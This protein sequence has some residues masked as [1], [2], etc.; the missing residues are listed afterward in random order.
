MPQSGLAWQ[1]KP[2]H[3]VLVLLVL[4]SACES[5]EPP[6]PPRVAAAKPA[7]RMAESTNART[8]AAP[9]LPE[10]A[11]RA[12]SPDP[13]EGMLLVPG[14]TFIMGADEGGEPDEQPA[15]EVTVGGFFLDRTEVTNQAY[16]VCVEAQKCGAHFAKSAELNGFGSDRA[17]RGP[18]QPVSAVGWHDAGAYCAFVNRR[19][20]TEAEWERAARGADGRRYP[21]GDDEPTVAH[22]RYRSGQT[23]DV[24]SLPAGAGPYGHLDLAGNVWEWVADPYDPLAYRRPS[25]AAGRVPTCSEAV[26]AY[27]E[28]RAEGKRGFTGSNPIPTECE[29]VLRG[30]AFNYFPGG[31]RTTNRVHHEPTARLVMSGFRCAADIPQ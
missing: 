15:H 26:A 12:S 8:S 2:V 27:V 9:A 19:L 30:G 23:A 18:E 14:G 22:A 25:A 21:W 16:A 4:V 10:L 24:G 28:L 11:P 20:P 3:R 5:H 1:D 13:P 29:Y 7:E 17:F 31:L 6:A